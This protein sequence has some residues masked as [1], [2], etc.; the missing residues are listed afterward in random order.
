[1]QQHPTTSQVAQPHRTVTPS[2]EALAKVFW[3]ALTTSNGDSVTNQACAHAYRTVQF[4]LL[5]T[6]KTICFRKQQANQACAHACRTR[7]SIH[8]SETIQAPGRGVEGLG[9][10]LRGASGPGRGY[11]GFG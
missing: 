3:S 7:V 9:R 11:G 6:N 5:S 10:S 8:H 1:M 4:N 2:E